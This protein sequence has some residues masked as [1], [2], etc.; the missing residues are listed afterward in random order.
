MIETT[1]SV[2]V[3]GSGWSATDTRLEAMTLKVKNS[4]PF[5][6]SETSSET[7]H[8]TLSPDDAVARETLIGQWPKHGRCRLS[9]QF[10]NR[11][12]QSM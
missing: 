4:N 11:S 2:G 5:R 1:C 6:T 12:Y 9:A 7:I 8:R 3:S 10:R